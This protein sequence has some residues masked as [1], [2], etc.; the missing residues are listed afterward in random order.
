MTV[1][2]GPTAQPALR[3]RDLGMHYVL[4]DGAVRPALRDV[5]FEV[6]AGSF[7]AVVGQ[8]GC[9]KTTLL[10]LLMGLADPTAGSIEV[11]GSPAHGRDRRCAMVFQH[12]E[13][14]PWRTARSNVAFGL[15]VAGMPAAERSALADRMLERVGLR[16]VCDLRPH[17]LSGGM[18]QRVGL[19]R[20]LATDPDILLMDEPFGALDACTRGDLQIDLNR[21]HEETGKTIV[22]VTHDVDEAAALADRMLVL[23]PSGTV[24]SDIVTGLPRP[25]GDLERVRAT[26]AFA[27]IRYA[28]ARTLRAPAIAA[29]D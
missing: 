19:A 29:A 25:R 26:A 24:A 1:I 14:L 20:A 23:T 18:R 15:E 21:L 22:F 11:F 3:V 6:E 10:R 17:Q 5:T 16:E 8:S 27:E 28:T 9:G 4:P 13:L 2:A 12:A 7:V